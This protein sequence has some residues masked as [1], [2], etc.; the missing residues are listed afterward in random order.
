MSKIKI[1]AFT[2]G[3]SVNTTLLIN[4]VSKGVTSSGAPYLSISFQDNTGNIEAKLWDAKEDQVNSAVA[5]RVVEV[6]AEVLKYRSS[7]QL[8]VNRIN[9]VDQQEIDLADFVISS[10]ISTEVLKQKV[11]DTIASMKNEV[12]KKIVSTMINKAENNFY[13]YPAAAKNH[14]S[15]VGGLATHVVGM[16]D[17]A[18]EICK[19]YPQLNRDLLIAGVI[20]HDFGKMTE[21]SGPVLTEYTLEGKL[22]GHISIMQGLIGETIKELG[23]ENEEYVILLRHLILSHHGQYDYGSPVLPQLAE[24]EVLNIIDNLD[25]RLN[26]LDKALSLTDAGSFTARVFSLENRAFYKPSK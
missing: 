2:E 11:N 20:L 8:R 10:S 18:Y 9:N 19:L 17:L 1:S 24:A 15:F 25:A 4:Q 22:I 13:D 21:L 6:H 16:L 26:T 14:H 23:L 7:L 3:Q 5:G 12:L